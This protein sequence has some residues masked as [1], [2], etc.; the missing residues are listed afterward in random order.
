M[1]RL[2][3]LTL[4]ASIAL[5]GCS[6]ESDE[7]D[8]AEAP[9]NDEIEQ[10]ETLIETA[11]AVLEDALVSASITIEDAW[12]RTPMTGRDMTAG[13]ASIRANA[14]LTLTGASSPDADVIELHSVEMDEQNVM[15]MRQTEMM[16]LEDGQLILQPGGNH[17]MIF[18]LSPEAVERGTVDI[19]LTF[20]SG[21]VETVTFEM[22]VG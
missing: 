21:Q 4:C 9:S 8:T 1:W 15:R 12:V 18:G 14:P 2:I 6:P 3:F 10:S 20:A 19:T 16:V 5:V 13:Y 7:R 22:R 17:L 11:D